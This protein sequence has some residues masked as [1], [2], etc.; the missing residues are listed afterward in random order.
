[1]TTK[2]DEL[3]IEGL[4]KLKELEFSN[5]PESDEID[6]TFS[7]EYIKTKDKLLN[8]LE[9][10]YWKYINTIAK[11]A[12]VIIIALII[13]FSSLMTVDATREKIVDFIY[14][15]YYYFSEV[16]SNKNYSGE[17]IKKYY[18]IRTLPTDFKLVS[19]NNDSERRLYVLWMDAKEY[20][21]TFSQTVTSDTN[22]F[23]SEHG[24]LEESN[25]N[26]T[27]CLICKT[28]TDF[29]C[30]WEFDGYR[31]ELVYPIDL[32]EEFMSEVVGNL[33][34]IDPAELEH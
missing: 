29:F 14:N 19:F 1:M 8:K 34:E 22:Q 16:K 9:R 24:V 4:S 31:F 27:P 28:N 6:Y 10:S 3:L 25:I 21:I 13:S 33:V 12:A 11:K 18:S 15:I 30:Y 5:I 7:A 17:L 32:G 23:D 26:N 20:C 2:Y